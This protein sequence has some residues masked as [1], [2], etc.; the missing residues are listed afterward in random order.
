[1]SPKILC[2]TF[3]E[4]LYL[5]TKWLFGDNRYIVPYKNGLK[6]KTTN[7]N[8]RDFTQRNRDYPTKQ[9]LLKNQYLLILHY[10]NLNNIHSHLLA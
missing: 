4:I 9:R 5:Y 6:N 1:M 3:F 10:H 7:S 2:G 8:F